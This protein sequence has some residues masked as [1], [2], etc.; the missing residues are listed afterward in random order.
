MMKPSSE[1]EVINR[2]ALKGEGGEQYHKQTKSV[3]K[4]TPQSTLVIPIVHF[5]MKLLFPDSSSSSHYRET[6][7]ITMGM[8]IA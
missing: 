4:H 1:R 2:L 6:G 7:G 8:L 3:R 5:T